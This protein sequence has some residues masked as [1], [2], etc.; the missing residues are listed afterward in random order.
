M[1]ASGCV[2]PAA[3]ARGAPRRP[4][5]PRHPLPRTCLLEDGVGAVEGP[6]VCALQVFKCLRTD[7]P[8]LVIHPLPPRQLFGVGQL[9]GLIVRHCSAPAKPNGA[10][11]AWTRASA[12]AGPSSKAIP[13]L[14]LTQGTCLGRQ[15]VSAFESRQNAVFA[16]CVPFLW[17]PTCT[18][19]FWFSHKRY[20]LLGSPLSRRTVFY[21]HLLLRQQRS[22]CS[23]E[24]LGSMAE[25]KVCLL[26]LSLRA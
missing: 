5:G 23:T 16:K 9:F 21:Y 18:A 12:E 8:V 10:R 7:L 17:E 14:R 6:P 22:R 15:Q 20:T 3:A 19:Y 4:G 1:R 2:S 26:N 11:R 13:S 24:G 25:P